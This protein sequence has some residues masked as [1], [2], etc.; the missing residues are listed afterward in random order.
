MQRFL[1]PNHDE[2]VC[3]ETIE[4][5][6]GNLASLEG[7]LRR[8]RLLGTNGAVEI[9]CSP[10]YVHWAVKLEYRV[11]FDVYRPKESHAV[12]TTEIYRLRL[13]NLTT[14]MLHCRYVIESREPKKGIVADP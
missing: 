1:P 8:A 4:G 7:T 14:P 9:G 11:E 5:V 6:G 10:I 13:G 3:M 12:T 2:L